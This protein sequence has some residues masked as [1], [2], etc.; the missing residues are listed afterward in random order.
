MIRAEAEK[1]YDKFED[2]I[3]ERIDAIEDF[4]EDKAGGVID[5]FTGSVGDVIK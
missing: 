3:E 1:M 2:K 4:V 5:A